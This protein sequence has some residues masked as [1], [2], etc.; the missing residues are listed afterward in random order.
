MWGGTPGT[1]PHQGASWTTQPSP[2]LAWS[3]RDGPCQRHGAGHD[4]IGTTT[5]AWRSHPKG[6]GGRPMW[7]PRRERALRWHN[8]G[9]G[10]DGTLPAEVRWA[11]FHC[12]GSSA[13]EAR[14]LPLLGWDPLVE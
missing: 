12:A 4:S 7:S 1:N 10:V 11:S 2:S 13:G 5:S 8:W 9:G 6:G 3:F 14:S